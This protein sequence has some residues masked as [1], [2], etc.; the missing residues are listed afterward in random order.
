MRENNLKYE[1]LA[2]WMGYIKR[3]NQIHC[4]ENE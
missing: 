2:E 4:R 3:D 1:K